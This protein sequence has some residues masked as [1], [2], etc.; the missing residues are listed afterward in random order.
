MRTSL[1]ESYPNL[2]EGAVSGILDITCDPCGICDACFQPTNDLCPWGCK[3]AGSHKRG[4]RSK[5]KD[6]DSEYMNPPLNPV[7]SYDAENDE[8][9]VSEKEYHTYYH[10]CE[11]C[12]KKNQVRREKDRYRFLARLYVRLAE[13]YAAFFFRKQRQLACVEEEDEIPEIEAAYYDCAE[14]PKN[15]FE[16]FKFYRADGSV[17]MEL[18]LNEEGR[19]WLGGEAISSLA[20]SLKCSCNY[21]YHDLSEY[22]EWIGGLYYPER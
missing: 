8:E 11:P 4:V 9:N 14:Q 19:H 17:I 12:M 1:R 15:P 21:L 16:D 22:Y 20:E 5:E 10:L 13:E 7:Y 2:A 18:D 3:G 6:G